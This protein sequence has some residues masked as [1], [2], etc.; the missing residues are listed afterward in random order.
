MTG[1]AHIVAKP[2]RRAAGRIANALLVVVCLALAP[3]T[4][5]S[6]VDDSPFGMFLPDGYYDGYAKPPY[7]DALD[8]GVR[9]VRSGSL[10]AYWNEIERPPL[11]NPPRYD[12]TEYDG[13]VA[14][15][16]PTMR[17]LANVHTGNSPFHLPLRP[18]SFLPVDEA[19]YRKFVRALVER[20]DGDGIDDV[21]GLVH[22]I[23]HWQVDNEPPGRENRSDYAELLRIAYEEIKAADPSS[24]VMIGGVTGGVEVKSGWRAL[25]DQEY[26]PILD[27]LA[28]RYVDIMDVHWF[29]IGDDSYRMIDGDAVRPPAVVMEHVRATMNAAGFSPTIPIWVTE[30]SS[31]SG[32]PFHAPRTEEQQ[33]RELFKKFVHLQKLGAAKIFVSKM[34]DGLLNNNRYFDFDGLIHDGLLANDLGAGVPKLSYF[35]Y[36]VMAEKLAGADWSTLTQL[37]DGTDADRLYLVSL[38]RDG[39]PV[40]IAWW[41]FFDDASYR[42]G[43]S[44]LLTFDG[45]TAPSVRVTQVVPNG[46]AGGFLADY[47]SAFEP[48]SAP[49]AAGTVSIPLDETPVVIEQV[50]GVCGDGNLD[51]GEACDDGN[52]ID[53]DGC[54]VDC[55]A[56]LCRNGATLGDVTLTIGKLGSTV[57]D[58]TLTLKGTIEVPTQSSLGTDLASVGAQIRVTALQPVPVVPLDLS[59]RRSPIPARGSGAD[60]GSSKDGWRGSVL[61]ADYRNASNALPPRCIAGSAGGLQ[62]FSVS[63]GIGRDTA[64]LKLR[65]DARKLALPLAAVSGAPLR[66][67]VVFGGDA[68]AGE[69]GNCASATLTDCVTSRA[70]TRAKCR[71]RPAP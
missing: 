8:V 6:D 57:G 41:D 44:R 69:A 60:C 24:L 26:K 14:A 15:V 39:E 27:A 40:W 21:P 19:R 2:F 22:P 16:P 71:T 35:T 53:G 66:V 3:A 9:W 63:R 29:G 32:Y 10:F 36:R 30:Q 34:Y 12:W 18:G 56:S 11:Q 43:E 58:E 13:A 1:R 61:R 38:Q 59:V 33:A 70:G 7:A 49:V 62:R 51:A 23:K 25:F 20:Y 5:A 28:G 52:A 64:R 42:P 67:V 65:V 55:R 54:D 68:A 48:I 37:R 31:V 45:A 46:A 4:A 47:A 50:Q 17:I